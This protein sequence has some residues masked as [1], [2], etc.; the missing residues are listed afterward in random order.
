MVEIL[1]DLEVE[2]ANPAPVEAHLPL[3][4]LSLPVLLNREEVP[5]RHLTTM[6]T[7]TMMTTMKR[8]R[9]RRKERKTSRLRLSQFVAQGPRGPLRRRLLPTA[10]PPLG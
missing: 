10:P 3:L 9:K 5:H 6:K 2:G 1:V 4:L 8:T 7:S